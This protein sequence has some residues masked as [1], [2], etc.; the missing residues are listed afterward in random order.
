MK[1][2]VEAT[3]AAVVLQ[4]RFRRRTADLHAASMKAMGLS[5]TKE[6]NKYT[7]GGMMKRWSE[8]TD[9]IIHTLKT[10][11]GDRTAAKLKLLRAFGNDL[12]IFPPELEDEAQQ[13]L[14]CRLMCGVNLEAG[15]LLFTEGTEGDQMF[16]VL[17]GSL[18]LMLRGRL[19]R[20]LGFGDLFCEG[21]LKG[22]GKRTA[23]AVA[24]GGPCAILSLSRPHFLRCSSQLWDHARAI[25]QTHSDLRTSLQLNIVEAVIE[26]LEFY[27]SL[28]MP[29]V[30]RAVCRALRWRATGPGEVVCEQGE[31]GELFFIVGMGEVNVTIDGAC[32]P[33][34]NTQQ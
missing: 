23:T 24:H 8:M 20:V 18:R 27:R 9:M 32:T 13:Q 15:E 21:A 25:L 33:L 29:K 30:R 7:S 16:F 28:P 10:P 22:Q 19:M 34:N 26:D 17:Q 3:A 11:N 6:G 5:L 12:G 14:C 4:R 31:R 1:A 2:S